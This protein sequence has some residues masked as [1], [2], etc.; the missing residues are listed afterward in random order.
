MNGFFFYCL[1]S[2]V[3]LSGFSK[4]KYFSVDNNEKRIIID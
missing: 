1:G 3:L 4:D 2:V